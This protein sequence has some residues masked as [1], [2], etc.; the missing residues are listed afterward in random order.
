MTVP[1]TATEVIYTENGSTLIYPFT[2]FSVLEQTDLLVTSS[3]IATGQQTTLVLGVDYTVQ[4]NS[5][6]TGQIVKTVALSNSYNL[7]IQRVLAITQ[8][9]SFVDNVGTDAATFQEA[10]DR[11]TMIAQQLQA[12][13]NLATLMPVGS[14]GPM[15]LPTPV[16]GQLLGWN[17]GILSNFTVPNSGPSGP[18][19]PTTFVFL[20]DGVTN[21]SWRFAIISSKCVM[22]ELVSGTWT[23]KG[24]WS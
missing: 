11:L 22:Q 13:I 2:T 3:N 5:D 18:S 23:T 17:N 1:N 7:I 21:G 14:T 9:I 10:F 24:T 4:L 8:E 12:E 20:G 16:Q 15:I 6:G 19:F